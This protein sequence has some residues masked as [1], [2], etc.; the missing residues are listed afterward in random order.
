MV[1]SEEKVMNE[2]FPVPA[3]ENI[4]GPGRESFRYKLVKKLLDEKHYTP[5]YQAKKHVTGQGYAATSY[6]EHLQREGKVNEAGRLM[7]HKIRRAKERIEDALEFGEL[8]VPHLYKDTEMSEDE[9]YRRFLDEYVHLDS[10]ILLDGDV[11]EFAKEKFGMSRVKLIT[12]FLEK[13]TAIYDTQGFVIGENIE[14]EGYNPEILGAIAASSRDNYRK[15]SVKTTDG[16]FLVTN[17]EDHSTLNVDRRETPI[18]SGVAFYWDPLIQDIRRCLGDDRYDVNVTGVDKEGRVFKLMP[19]KPNT[20]PRNSI[21]VNGE[22]FG[23]AC[24]PADKGYTVYKHEGE[25]ILTVGTIGLEEINGRGDATKQVIAKIKSKS[26]QP[27]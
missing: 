15:L 4:A 1:V 12:N 8:F 2:G 20:F 6:L 9:K 3:E 11:H 24:N 22:K 16:V 10:Q 17:Y 5:E 21:N 14:K 18:G 23:Y 25:R 13:G 7:K 26:Y 27:I 19:E